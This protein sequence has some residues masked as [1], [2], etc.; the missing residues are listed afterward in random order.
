M[1]HVR[2][3]HRILGVL[4]LIEAGIMFLCSLFSLCYGENDFFTF[5]ISS[6]ITACCGMTFMLIGKSTRHKEGSMTRRDG[7]IVVALSWAMFSI[8]GSLPY[9][10]GGYLPSFTD[11]FFE[12]MSGFTTTGATIMHDIEVMPHGILFWRSLTQWIGGLGIVF[13]TVAVLPIFGVGD[14][15][16]FAAEA[17]GPL[18][19]KLHPRIG[20]SGRWILTVYVVLTVACIICLRLCGMPSYDSINHALCTIATGGYSIKN[21]SIAYY[22]S[23]CIEYVVMLFMFLA[24]INYGLLFLF[25]FKGKIRKLFTDSEFKWYV[26][27]LLIF[28]G[29]IGLGLIIGMDEGVEEAF[30][31]STFQVISSMTSTG[32]TI[33]DFEAWPAVLWMAL[34]LCMFM[35]ACAGST[36]GAM[37]SIR[38]LVLFKTLKNEFNRI[39]HPNAVLPVRIS[40]KTISFA[41]KQSV[42]AFTIFYIGII[43]IAWVVFMTIGLEFT[44]SYGAAV[45]MIGNTGI[46]VGRMGTTIP[47]ADLPTVGKWFCSVLMLIGRLEIFAVLIILTPAFWKHR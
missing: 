45:S 29:L 18:H 3:I 7:Y 17:T 9:F 26:T 15:Q 14:V 46:T 12:T 2:I 8:F 39:L 10:I 44:D 33:T 42:L 32:F 22:N 38:T 28:S 24:G 27:S 20:V 35:G 25:M 37:K 6:L 13:F 43:F 21:A 16:L 11:A 47:W 4:L 31:H 30:R 19:G 41:T 34:S 23:T 1:I 40:G 36:S 5:V